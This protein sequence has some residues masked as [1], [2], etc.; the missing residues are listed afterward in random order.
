V[1]PGL[2]P[3]ENEKTA[4]ECCGGTLTRDKLMELGAYTSK[5]HTRPLYWCAFAADAHV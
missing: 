1:F 3:Q 4:E 5:I 2:S